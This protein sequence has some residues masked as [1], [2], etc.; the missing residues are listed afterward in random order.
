M[1]AQLGQSPLLPATCNVARR[2]VRQDGW[3]G[4]LRQILRI[5]ETRQDLLE[6]DER[7]LKDI[8]LTRREAEQEAGRAPWDVTTPSRRG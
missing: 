3:M 5:V 4:F 8:G 1:S 7:M 2:A 6:M